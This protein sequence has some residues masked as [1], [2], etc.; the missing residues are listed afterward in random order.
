MNR[1]DELFNRKPAGI[2]NIFI[3]AGYPTLHALEDILPALERSGADLVEIGMPYSDPLADGTTIQQS[4][5]IA[6]QNG[7]T[8]ELL[9]A[10]LRVIRPK[11]K[12]PLV[13]MGYY[14]QVM[15]FGEDRFLDQ[16]VKAGIDGLILPDLPMEE[17]EEQL[18]HKCQERGIGVSFLI[19]PQTSES[20]IRKA[21]ALSRGF[22]YMVAD[23]SIT[24]ASNGISNRQIEYFERIQDLA[25]E[26]PRLIGFG[27]S[28]AAAFQTASQYSRG[29]IIGSAFIR[30]L[31]DKSDVA[32]ASGEFVQQILQT[33]NSLS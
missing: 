23:A 6:L 28:D 18:A 1:I 25:L 29:A 2:L 10:Q 13:I 33:E 16:C 12:L 27:I 3:T 7:M 22:L 5:Q 15:Q 19:T 26:T 31:A 32:S 8:L 21:D 17:Y 30:A 4:S 11:I 20:R 14:N 9:F 24:G